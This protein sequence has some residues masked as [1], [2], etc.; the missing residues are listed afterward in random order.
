MPCTPE[1]HIKFTARLARKLSPNEIY[2]WL[3]TEGY[4]SE[5]YVLPPCFC[6]SGIP[7]RRQTYFKHSKQKYRP[8]LSECIYVHFPRTELTDRTFGIM[9]PE[10]H[11]DIA[12]LIAKNWKTLLRTLFNPKNKVCW[13]SFPVPLDKRTPGQVGK[14]RMECACINISDRN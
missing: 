4:F 12:L 8:K 3:I 5:N 10:L 11:S 9:D 2:L 13:Y 1:T 6:V 7:N 14:L